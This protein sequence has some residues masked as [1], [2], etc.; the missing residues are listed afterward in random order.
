VQSTAERPSGPLT[1][2]VFPGAHC[3]GNLYQDD[4]ATFAYRQGETLRMHFTCDTASKDVQL[5]IHI[6][7]HEGRYAAWWKQ[8]VLEVNGIARPVA[9]VTVNG[10]PADF[11]ATGNGP[12]RISLPDDGNGMEVL[13][14]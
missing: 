14:H 6:G 3:E 2:R 13:V 5:A 9:S 4:G 10:H 8:I 1:L 12:L 11:S 7:P